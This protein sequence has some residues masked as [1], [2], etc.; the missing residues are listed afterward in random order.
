M[1]QRKARRQRIAR[2]RA[3]RALRTRW[4]IHRVTR[5]ENSILGRALR[6][7]ARLTALRI[8]Y[9][10]D[11]GYADIPLASV[12]QSPSWDSIQLR[13]DHA[14]LHCIPFTYPEPN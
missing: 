1:T 5:V 6:T 10:V 11:L 14:E 4:V 12:E 9:G 2:N 7:T 13:P 3:R 8:F